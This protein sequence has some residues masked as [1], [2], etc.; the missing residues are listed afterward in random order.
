MVQDSGGLTKEQNDGDLID[1]GDE[2]FRCN[3]I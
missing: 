1:S 3:D 2:N